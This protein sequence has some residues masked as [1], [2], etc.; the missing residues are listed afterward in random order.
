MEPLVGEQVVVVSIL[1]RSDLGL[2]DIDPNRDAGPAA[3]G[4]ESLEA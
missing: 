1:G 3:G 2:A 4:M